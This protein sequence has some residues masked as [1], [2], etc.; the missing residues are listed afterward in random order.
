MTHYFVGELL[1]DKIGD[2]PLS[3]AENFKKRAGGAPA[4][5]AVAAS[6]LGAEAK[7]V[8]TVGDDEFG[9]FLEEKLEKESVDISKIHRSEQKTTLAFV[10][11][12]KEGKP[13]FSFY[14]GAD[15]QISESQLN[16]DL[17]PEDT[18]HLGSLPFT[19]EE[20]S[21][22]LIDLIGSTDAH[23]SFD[24]NL[25]KELMSPEYLERLKTVVKNSDTV[26]AAEDELEYFGGKEELSEKVSELVITRGDKGAT[27]LSGKKEF[28]AE[29]KDVEVVDTTGAGD[30]LTG[31]YLVF[32]SEG[33]EFA[34]EKAVE[35]ASN[36]VQAKGAMSSLPRAEDLT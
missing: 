16:L 36:S 9:D 32:R 13:E 11:L 5:V 12:D 33:K 8:A 28:S 18:V 24:P 21:K 31:S 34:L 20:V 27:L 10:G 14:R 3:E 23:V 15:K 26:F 22:R 29:A 35:A 6:K 7:V 19:E 25:R 1:V 2:G 4:N 30:A 17:S